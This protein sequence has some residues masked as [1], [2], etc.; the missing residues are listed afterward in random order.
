ML[1]QKRAIEDEIWFLSVADAY[2]KGRMQSDNSR[3]GVINI[4]AVDL[5]VVGRGR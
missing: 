2:A 4:V 5:D 3:E 1:D